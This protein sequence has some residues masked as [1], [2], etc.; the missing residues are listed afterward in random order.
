MFV[1]WILEVLES[2]RVDVSGRARRLLYYLLLSL[3][4]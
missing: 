1:V 2:R 4:R 3:G